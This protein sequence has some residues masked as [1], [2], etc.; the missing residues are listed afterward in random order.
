MIGPKTPFCVWTFLGDV[1][2]QRFRIRAGHFGKSNGSDDIVF[3]HLEITKVI[4]DTLI[5][6]GTVFL[7]STKALVTSG[8][9][10]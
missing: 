1:F 10:T 5:S 9:K 2:Q 4:F 8:F 7:A 3:Y 6:A